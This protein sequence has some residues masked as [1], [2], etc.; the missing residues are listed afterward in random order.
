M[1]DPWMVRVE[2]EG[3]DD[4]SPIAANAP[5]VAA[6]VEMLDELYSGSFSFDVEEARLS[7]MVLLQAEDESDAV[8]RGVKVVR[9]VAERTGLPLWDTVRVDAMT[10]AEF[11]RGLDKPLYPQVVGTSEVAKMLGVT[12]QRVSQLWRQ[13]A[14]FPPPLAVLEC[15]PIWVEDWLAEFARVWQ[16]KS[17]RPKSTDVDS[18]TPVDR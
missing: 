6:V 10:E 3:P 7:I 14:N 11:E 16:R 12:R 5:Q 2:T 18:S 13:N 8:A 9:Q 4:A 1:A 17:G 15:G